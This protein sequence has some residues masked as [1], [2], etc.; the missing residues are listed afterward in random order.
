M[1]QKEIEE[2]QLV[3]KVAIKDHIYRRTGEI[4]KYDPA[5]TFASDER[6]K[7]RQ[8][9]VDIRNISDLYITCY[10]WA[11][12]FK[13]LLAS[14]LIPAVVK[15]KDDHAYVESYIYG[16][17]YFSDLML[18]LEDIK[19]I[20]F[21][22]KSIHNFRLTNNK[23]YQA[24]NSI[25]IN[26][27]SDTNSFN[28]EILLEQFKQRLDNLKSKMNYDQY[29]YQTFKIAEIFINNF[30]SKPNIGFISGIKFICHL[31]Q[32]FISNNYAPY[33]THFFDV[34]RGVYK[35]IY[36][37][38]LNENIKYFAYEQNDDGIYKLHEVSKETIDSY[39]NTFYSMR[40]YNLV[41]QKKAQFNR[42]E[43]TKPIFMTKD[44][45]IKIKKK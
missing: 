18:N 19:R 3:D 34:E 6:E 4:F 33:N 28:T 26:N 8:K 36:S 9:R 27:S 40:S 42:K 31:L 13:D 12:M 38:P 2:L 39:M 43:V 41:L 10:S 14:F 30:F 24:S 20:K 23:L 22:M 11:Y 29:V 5:W 35:E 7:L 16:E 45:Y 25:N 32:T 37:I 15:I 44:E 17:T 1:M 21:G